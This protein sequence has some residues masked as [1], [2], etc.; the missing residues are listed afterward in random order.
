[1]LLYRSVFLYINNTIRKQMIM[2]IQ[3]SVLLELSINIA[4]AHYTA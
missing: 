1:M 3:N 2:E 4:Y